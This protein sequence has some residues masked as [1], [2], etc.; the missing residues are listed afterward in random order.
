[1]MMTPKEFAKEYKI[2]YWKA[3]E[4]C[5]LGQL[6]CVKLGK[7]YRIDTDKL[8]YWQPDQIVQQ[9]QK[10]KA[11]PQRRAKVKDFDFMAALN[12]LKGA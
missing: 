3:M 1:M 8:Q 6:P 2:G 12:G 5:R 4:L 9:A 11:Q 10:Q 7:Q